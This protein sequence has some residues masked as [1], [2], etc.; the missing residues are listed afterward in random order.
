MHYKSTPKMCVKKELGTY[1][2]KV[3][4]SEKQ[5]EKG[6]FTAPDFVL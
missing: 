2:T 4:K 1:S 6:F 3:F 5:Y